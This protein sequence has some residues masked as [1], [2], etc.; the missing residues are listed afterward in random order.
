M[1]DGGT[2]T[3]MLRYHVEKKNVHLIFSIYF[4]IGTRVLIS[5]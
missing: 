2:R 4:E 3:T 5:L 1:E